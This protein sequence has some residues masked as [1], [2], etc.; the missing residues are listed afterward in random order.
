MGWKV[1]EFVTNIND[2]RIEELQNSEHQSWSS[3]H[4][5]TDGSHDGLGPVENLI[6]TAVNKKFKHI[7]ITEHGR[8]ASSIAVSVL[9]KKHGIKS[10]IGNEV[11]LDIGNGKNHH[12]TVLADGNVGFNNLVRLNNI[13]FAGDNKRSIVTIE[14]LI[15]YNEGLYVLSGCPVSPMQFLGWNEAKDIAFRLKKVFG[16]RLFAEIMFSTNNSMP[17]WERSKELSEEFDIPLVFTNDVHFA[18]REDAPLHMIYQKMK[19][20]SGFNYD[21]K[22]LWLATGFELIDR[23]S[24]FNYGDNA[25]DLLKIGMTNSFLLA[26]KL[27]TVEFSS[28]PKLPHIDNAEQ[29]LRDKVYDRYKTLGFDDSV[30]R[31]RIESELDVIISKGYATY[32]LIV[33]DL[34]TNARRNGVTIGPGRGSAVGSFVAYLL[35]I[36]EVNPLYYGL[37][38]ER[39]LN[40]NRKAMP[41]IDSDIPA[42][43][44]SIVL[45]YAEKKYGAYSIATQVRYTEK[46]LIRDICRH[47]RITMDI[48]NKAAEEGIDGPTCSKLS[49]DYENFRELYDVMYGQIRH[50]GKHAGGIIIVDDDVEVPLEKMKDGSLAT[51]WCEGKN[52]ELSEA[53]IVK[54]DM[55]GLSALDI[56]DELKKTTG[57]DPYVPENLHELY[58]LPEFDL[59]KNGKVL[60]VFQLTGSHGMREYAKQVAP[61]N[62][63]DIIAAVSLWRTGPIRAKAHEL[64]LEARHGN[65]RLIHP[66][67]DEILKDTYGLIVY[68]E[69]FMRLYAWAT[70]RDLGDADN[71]RRVIVK[72]KP[73]NT[74]SEFALSNL[75]DEFKSGSIHKGLTK[76][77]ANDLW[78]EIV[79]H[80]GYS[81]N[82]SHATAYSMITWKM[83]WYKYHY[84]AQF[85]TAMLNN[86][87]ER[88]QEYIFDIVAEGFDVSFP[89]INISSDKYETDGSTIYLP[90]TAIKGLGENAAVEIISNRPYNTPEQ[91][92]K[93]VQK[94]KV[95][96]RNRVN[97]FSLGAF[98]K[99][100][101]SLEEYG[102]S[103]I[104]LINV[105]DVAK[106]KLFVK[107]TFKKDTTFL[108]LLVGNGISDQDVTGFIDKCKA[109]NISLKSFL[110]DFIDFIDNSKTHEVMNPFFIKDDLLGMIGAIR[111]LVTFSKD[112]SQTRLLGVVIPTKQRMDIIQS[113]IRSGGS[114]GVVLDIEQK[115][116]HYN[117]IYYRLQLYPGRNVWTVNLRGVEVGDWIAGSIARKTGKLMQWGKI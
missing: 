50:Q 58:D 61:R 103:L 70:D 48:T 57:V 11:Y 113:T 10:I 32:F 7:G 4:T 86:D 28:T 112:K 53:G 23:V 56:L 12:L 21:S 54:F 62:I 77:Q 78:S 76:E 102:G 117:P 40:P 35:G 46:M 67:V 36:T 20:Y 115:S 26:E 30:S 41:D 55:L 14:N 83:L 66:E 16:D 74:D 17:V 15:K 87:A 106:C 80:T 2:P 42:T 29:V 44:R 110:A 105:K 9:A 88:M 109:D 24:G 84:P 47:F 68:Q 19:S 52:A 31:D 33:E 81:F 3:L 71:A 27:K 60:G 73:G 49:K 43:K 85:Y 104:D 107:K 5:H 72:Y 82:K 34:I 98:D 111:R 101:G 45:D 97:L 100:G 1:S 22:M 63:N 69:D 96:S 114:G 116:S 108:W 64:F 65:P 59:I 8:L 38:F 51:S 93:K 94:R 79:T 92:V 13:G 18:E 99:I 37:Y 6:K 95:N 25:L 91:F 75:E 90:L 89:D 39:F